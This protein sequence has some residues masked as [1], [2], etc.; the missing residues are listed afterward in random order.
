MSCPANQ[1][2]FPGIKKLLP[3]TGISL[4]R[5]VDLLQRVTE[6]AQM[7]LVWTRLPKKPPRREHKKPSKW[8]FKYD[9]GFPKNGNNFLHWYA[10][11]PVDSRT[12]K[13]R[14]ES[15]ATDAAQHRS[16]IIIWLLKSYHGCLESTDRLD[17]LY[18]NYPGG[19][20]WAWTESYQDRC[21]LQTNASGH[22]RSRMLLT[23]V[24]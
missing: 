2:F 4:S 23:R 3:G 7:S 16:F 19:P 6:P 9:F 24:Q 15:I 11:I 22:E 1:T 5:F 14:R 18:S 13:V 12:K 17:Q 10:E 21:Q 20:F 8:F